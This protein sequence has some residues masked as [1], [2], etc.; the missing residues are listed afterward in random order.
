MMSLEIHSDSNRNE[1]KEFSLGGG[2]ARPANKADIL[3]AI[4]EP[5][6]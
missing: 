6:V 5:I 1:Y 2:K 4:C 3:N